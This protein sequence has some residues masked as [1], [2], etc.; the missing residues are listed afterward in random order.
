MVLRFFSSLLIGALTLFFLQDL[1]LYGAFK[2]NQGYIAENLCVDR[3]EPES[4]C[5]G[6]CHLKQ[7]VDKKEKSKEKQPVPEREQVYNPI[8]PP[9]K[10]A[11]QWLL[12]SFEVHLIP[13]KQVNLPILPRSVFHPPTF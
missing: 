7:E 3:D 11:W 10:D 1:V 4:S 8:F 2:L 9:F 5:N 12:Y 6:K 13:F